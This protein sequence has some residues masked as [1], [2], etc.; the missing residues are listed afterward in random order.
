MVPVIPTT[1]SA[2]SLGHEV[3]MNGIFPLRLRQLLPRRTKTVRSRIHWTLS[4]F[5][6]EIILNRTNLCIATTCLI[7]AWTLAGKSLHQVS[8]KYT[9]KRIWSL[10][11][12]PALDILRLKIKTDMLLE[13]PRC[14]K[15]VSQKKIKRGTSKRVRAKTSIE[16]PPAVYLVLNK[17]IILLIKIMGTTL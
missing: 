7:A 11:P 9:A 5:L 15:Q 17:M 16:H 13:V 14:A 1:S 10:S 6:S 3:T 12:W 4:E 2:G 8:C